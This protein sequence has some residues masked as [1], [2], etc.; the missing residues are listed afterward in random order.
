MCNVKNCQ[1]YATGRYVDAL[2]LSK[3]PFISSTQDH[4]QEKKVAFTMRVPIFKGG[5]CVCTE[6]DKAKRV[7]Q[8]W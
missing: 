3:I 4:K 6:Y 7:V 5:D 1:Y 2:V 8:D